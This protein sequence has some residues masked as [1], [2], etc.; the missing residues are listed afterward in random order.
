MTSCPGSR[1][2]RKNILKKMELLTTKRLHVMDLCAK[3]K[4]EKLKTLVLAYVLEAAEKLIDEALFFRPKSKRP[5]PRSM[6]TRRRSWRLRT[7]IVKP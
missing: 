6:A 1:L 4:A 2:V 5:W 3:A 7:S